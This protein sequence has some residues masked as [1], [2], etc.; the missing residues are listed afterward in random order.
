MAPISIILYLITL[1]PVFKVF[2]YVKNCTI[3]D[4]NSCAYGQT[5]N[6]IDGEDC[7]I[8]CL[9]YQSCTES[10][11]NCP[12]NGDCIIQC[13]NFQS[14]KGATINASPNALLNVTCSGPHSVTPPN[15]NIKSCQDIT[16]NGSTHTT[17]N[18]H[19]TG[20]YSCYG[21]T[22]DARH[23]SLLQMLDCATELCTCYKLTIY[24]PPN[25]NGDKRCILQG[26]ATKY[27]SS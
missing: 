3:N 23:A 18:I 25:I 4:G 8:N 21:A 7:T 27:L 20:Q 10:T 11:F 13:T 22:I 1:S 2:G 24:C 19:C 17:I 9:D 14:C 15:A 5:V 26:N 16:I 12:K 6:C